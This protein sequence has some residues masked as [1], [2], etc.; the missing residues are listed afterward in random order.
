MASASL[1][2]MAKIQRLYQDVVADEDAY[3]AF[4]PI[5]L[6]FD[7]EALRIAAYS[8]SDGREA[9]R[10]LE[11]AADFAVLANYVPPVASVWAQDGRV[12]R[13]VYPQVLTRPKVP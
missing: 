3:L 13:D 7:A 5:A 12:L 8:P 4:I 2:I 1:A 6:P 11:A 9:A 10:A